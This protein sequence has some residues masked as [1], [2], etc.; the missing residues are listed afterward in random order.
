[1]K[2]MKR[3][4]LIQIAKDMGLQGYTQL[5]KKVL[6][7]LINNPPPPPHPPPSPSDDILKEIKTM[8][9]NQ[10][11]KKAKE[12]GLQRYSLLNKKELLELIKNPI[13]PQAR[14]RGIKRKVTLTIIKEDGECGNKFTFN[15][16]S[17][18]AKY[19]NIN[20]GVLGT[21]FNAK[22]EK[23]RNSVVI[24]GKTYRLQIE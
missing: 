15:A 2:K 10:L 11:R 17:Q 21:K 14:H 22:T 8:N 23:A 13:A 6:I 3:P 16:I 24:D 5:K 9:L 20:S 12:M 4:E 7:E 19:F 1:M 18:A